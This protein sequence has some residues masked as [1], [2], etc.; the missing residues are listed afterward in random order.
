MGD[1]WLSLFE[2]AGDALLVHVTDGEWTA[3]PGPNVPHGGAQGY[4][5]QNIDF[6]SENEA[7]A[8]AHD[9]DGPGLFR[10][11]VLHYKDGVW[12][13]RNWNW[14]FWDE[15]WFGLLGR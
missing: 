13:N 2:S 1:F 11:L 10:G 6:V 9:G 14:H 15:R 12:R 5:I 8:T 3:V 7:W 4:V